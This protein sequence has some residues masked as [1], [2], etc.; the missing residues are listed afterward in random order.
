M[1]WQVGFIMHTQ[2]A[3]P[4]YG[5]YSVEFQHEREVP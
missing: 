1:R 2:S 4:G 5:K 3:W